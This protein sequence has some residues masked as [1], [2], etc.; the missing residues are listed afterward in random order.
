MEKKKAFISI[1]LEGMPHIV[2]T[3]HLFE[4]GALYGEARKIATRITLATVEALHMNG[5]KEVIVADSHGPMVNMK[6]E[7]LPSYVNVVRGS[8]RPISMVSGIETCDI[9]LFLGYHSKAGT[10]KSTFDHTYSGSTVDFLE[11]NGKKVSEF[12][13]NSYVAGYYEVPVV[14]VAG[15]AKLLHD[16]AEA[17]ERIEKV[18]FKNSMSRY[19]AM[20]P[21]LQQIEQDLRKSVKRG[22]QR[23]GEVITVAS[24][25]EVKLRFI[26]SG[27]AGI[28][29]LLPIISRIDGKTVYYKVKN[30]VEAYNIFEALVF[31]SIGLQ[32]ITSPE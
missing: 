8:P 18:V 5:I 26:E 11:I 3:H 30:I 27:M 10:P 15:D 28:A 24:P 4:K 9:A 25:V 1:D 13:L 22:V 23:G 14:L 29:D 31:A 20:S 19:A 7:D 32:R 2:S 16:D 21:S 12:L 6:V 17:F